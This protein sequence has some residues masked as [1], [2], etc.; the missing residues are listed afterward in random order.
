MRKLFAA[1]FSLALVAGLAACGATGD[2][3][4]STDGTTAPASDETTDDTT[5]TEDPTET[6]EDASPRGE[7]GDEQAYVDALA[8]NLSGGEDDGQLVVSEQDAPC[9]AQGWVDIVGVDTL[10][11]AGVDP[12][13]LADPDSNFNTTDLELDVEQGRDM[14]EAAEDCGV[15]LLGQFRGFLTQGLAPDQVD[16][17]NDELDDDFLGEVI[18]QALVNDEP[19]ADLE[20]E[21]ERL[22]SVCSLS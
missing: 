9:V 15:D 7:G 11:G 22:D 2:D 18:A 14:V 20:D 21:F 10:A 3:D 8:A 4:G 13:E 16:C 17:L 5:V 19:S 6:T 1:L 12:D